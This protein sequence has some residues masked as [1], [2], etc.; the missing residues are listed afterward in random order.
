MILCEYIVLLHYILNH[1]NFYTNT[2]KFYD[3]IMLH[4][5]LV[6]TV[7]VYITLTYTIIITPL[8]M[9]LHWRRLRT[10]CARVSP[11]LYF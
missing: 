10:L 3:L 9:S 11:A 8:I 6:Y 4:M 2:D 7:I 1:M 5:I